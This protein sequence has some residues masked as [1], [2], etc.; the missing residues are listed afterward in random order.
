MTS[1]EAGMIVRDIDMRF[2]R[3]I[4]SV[5]RTETD[6][7]SILEI[8]SMGAISD[9]DVS[10]LAISGEARGLRLS[11]MIILILRSSSC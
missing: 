4:C 2:Q 10:R 8:L 3:R 9:R 7:S 11:T 5:F 6:R 1:L